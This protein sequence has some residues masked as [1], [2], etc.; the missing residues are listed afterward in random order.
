MS[1]QTSIRADMVVAMKSRDELKLFVLRG[2]LTLFTQ[3][4]TATKRTPQ[5]ALTDDEVL[6][7]IKR[8]VKQRRE[9][10]S[11]YEAGGRTDLADKEKAEAD[12][13]EAYLPAQASTEVILAAARACKERLGIVDKTG[14][15]KLM[16]A[17]M[18]ELK[19]TADGTAVRQVVESLL[20]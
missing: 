14:M 11:Q 1:L 12:I 10:A 4:L 18:A 8:S 5:D 6:G 16:G 20:T 3:E 15:G 17:V 2:L 13:L 9:A 19:G 7:L